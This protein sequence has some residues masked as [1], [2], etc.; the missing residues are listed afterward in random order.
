L[1]GR[2]VADD[3]LLVVN[4]LATA[5]PHERTG[6]DYRGDEWRAYCDGYYTALA[7]VARCIDG[8][9]RRRHLRFLAAAEQERDERARWTLT[10]QGERGIDE[11]RTAIPSGNARAARRDRERAHGDRARQPT[12]RDLARGTAAD[13]RARGRSRDRTRGGNHR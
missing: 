5:D 7:F 10:E 1:T 6:T 3:L 4:D 11:A 13:R 9:L 8:A 12:E 2:T